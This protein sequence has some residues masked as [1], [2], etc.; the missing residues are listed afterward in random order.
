MTGSWSI[1]TDIGGVKTHPHSAG[2]RV[3]MLVMLPWMND[4]RYIENSARARL[5]ECSLSESRNRQQ[6][7]SSTMTILMYCEKHDGWGYNTNSFW[8]YVLCLWDTDLCDSRVEF[9]YTYSLKIAKR[10]ASF[11]F[12][13]PMFDNQKYPIPHTC[14]LQRLLWTFRLTDVKSRVI[15]FSR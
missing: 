12:R 15:P 1:K 3:V 11:T 6:Y 10:R 8:C 2:N 4:V 14:G 9:L 7:K 5:T 13:Y